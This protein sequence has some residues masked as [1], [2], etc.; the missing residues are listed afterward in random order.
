MP[1]IF[2]GYLKDVLWC[3]EAMRHKP[4]EP[5][6]HIDDVVVLLLFVHGELDPCLIF[7]LMDG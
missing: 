3:D 4:P 2:A 1:V 7:T 6:G 5:M